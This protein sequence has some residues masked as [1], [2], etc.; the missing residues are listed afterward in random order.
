M[1]TSAEQMW[2]EFTE[3][4]HL[5]DKIFQ[6]RWFGDQDNPKEINKINEQLAK[7]LLLSTSNPL[8]FYA[9]KEDPIPQVGDYA[10]LLDGD[11]KPFNIIKTV[12]SEI[13]PFFKIS[14]EHAYHELESSLEEWQKIKKIEFETMMLNSSSTFSEND[15]VICEVVKLMT[16]Y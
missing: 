15:P 11:M 16:N 3:K 6:T 5:K 7:N 1:N 9:V 8:S 14:S 13:I 10:V 2:D 12:V 4:H